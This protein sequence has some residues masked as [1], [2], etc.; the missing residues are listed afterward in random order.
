MSKHPLY[1]TA[2]SEVRGEASEKDKLLLQSDVEQW[3]DAL[4]SVVDEVDAQLI[5][6]T[7]KFEDSTR[8]LTP[9]STEY[10]T[11][12]ESFETWKSRVRI[13][14]KH[15]SARLIAVKRMCQEEYEG[16]PGENSLGARVVAA[17]IGLY[18]VEN[19]E[20]PLVW[21]A[22]LDLL[23]SAVEDLQSQTS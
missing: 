13:F 15:I 22:A 4:Q 2:V 18:D 23:F 16:Q 12:L 6:E 21:D 1:D 10:E 17:A 11:A 3:R 20:D 9:G 7:D 14:K 5:V 8:N 19:C